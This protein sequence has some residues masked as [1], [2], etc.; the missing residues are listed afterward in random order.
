M[1]KLLELLIKLTTLISTV[2]PL[3]TLIL[4]KFK[5]TKPQKE[6][7][8]DI[9]KIL[10]K[11]GDSL[12][13]GTIFSNIYNYLKE[14]AFEA[15][16]EYDDNIKDPTVVSILILTAKAIQ[17]FDSVLLEYVESTKTEYDN[18]AYEFA[19]GWAA[20]YLSEHPE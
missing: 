8:M 6:N 5:K 11:I 15:L 16:D 4:G 7:N 10:I 17:Q 9:R 19:T 18:D 12:V 3:I 20:K 1:T 2:K 13:P 14:Q